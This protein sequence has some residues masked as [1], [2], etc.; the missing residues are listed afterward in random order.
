MKSERYRS[1]YNGAASKAVSLSR[2]VG[3]NPTLSAMIRFFKKNKKEPKNL[4]EVL[5]CF[6]NLEKDFKKFSTDLKKLKKEN[7]FSVQKIGIIR[8]NPFKEVGGDQSFSIALLNGENTDIVITSLYSQK[9]NRIYGKPI[10]NGKSQYSLS[11]EEKKAIE[12]AKNYK[13]LTE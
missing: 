1:G 7:K 2:H 3:S 8:F 12:E 4:K 6:K 5:S 13:N 11:E 10:K 9:G